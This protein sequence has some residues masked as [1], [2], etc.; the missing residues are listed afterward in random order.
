VMMKTA[1]ARTT[2]ATAMPPTVSTPIPEGA[3]VVVTTVVVCGDT[4]RGL[5]LRSK[6]FVENWF[7]GGMLPG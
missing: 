6:L 3:I 1:A 5:T 4:T 2:I 7:N